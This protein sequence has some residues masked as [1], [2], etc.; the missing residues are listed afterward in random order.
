MAKAAEK[1]VFTYR[2]RP[3]GDG[4]A[5]VWAKYD[6]DGEEVEVSEQMWPSEADAEKAAR[7]LVSGDD[8]LAVNVMRSVDKDDNSHTVFETAAP[9]EVKKFGATIAYAP[10]QAPR[11]TSDDMPTAADK[12]VEEGLVAQV[13]SNDEP[14]EAEAKARAK[15]AAKA[16]ADDK[17]AEKESA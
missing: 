9:E 8:V 12:A 11:P 1:E 5:F 14:T 4:R 7:I 3:T 2:T 10:D 15:S 13:A 17:K 16:A 6:V